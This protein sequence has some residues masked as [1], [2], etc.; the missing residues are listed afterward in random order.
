MYSPGWGFDTL[1]SIESNNYMHTL[2]NVSNLFWDLF[3]KP[4]EETTK[5]K[6]KW[7]YNKEKLK[8]SL[9]SF[10][11]ITQRCLFF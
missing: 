8:N 11:V 9:D 1:A 2:S 7:I 4:V 10:L 5:K 3:V 6:K